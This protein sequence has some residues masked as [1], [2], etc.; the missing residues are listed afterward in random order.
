MMK[1]KKNKKILILSEQ[2][3]EKNLKR[4]RKDNF[5]EILSK[6]DFSYDITNEEETKM[7]TNGLNYLGNNED[8]F[9]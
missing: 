5:N 1:L 8:E 4:N 2:R 7:L 9:V 3:I 6:I